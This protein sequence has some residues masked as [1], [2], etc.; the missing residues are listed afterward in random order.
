MNIQPNIIDKSTEIEAI[1][2]KYGD[3]Y[4]ANEDAKLEASKVWN[5][6]PNKHGVF[7]AKQ[8]ETIVHVGWCEGIISLYETNSNYWLLGVSCN[9]HY[10]GRSYAPSVWNYVG[11]MSY[12]DARL[13]GALK[14]ITFFKDVVSDENSCNSASNKANAKKALSILQDELNH[15][16]LLF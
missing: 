7:K 14:M 6:V 8:T 1:Q 11:Y 16:F 2:A 15:Q 9:S 4:F 13:A 5:G 3:R 12:Y 10:S